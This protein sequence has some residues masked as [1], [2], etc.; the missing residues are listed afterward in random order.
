MAF[1]GNKNASNN[2]CLEKQINFSTFD[3][4]LFPSKHIHNNSVFC[5]S[6]GINPT[7]TSNNELSYN[8]VDIESTLFGINSS[9]LIQQK[10]STIPSLKRKKNINFFERPRIFLPEPL[11]IEK[12]HRP[13]IFRK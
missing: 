5:D 4:N 7:Y 13:S 12:C 9:N 10:K 6:P 3:Y 2:Y 11:V 8:G 1:T